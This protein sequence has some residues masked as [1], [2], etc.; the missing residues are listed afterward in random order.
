ME[1]YRLLLIL[2]V[3][4]AAVWVGGHLVLSSTVLPRALRAQDPALLRDFE[5]RYERIGI[6]ALLVQVVTGVWLAHRWLPQPALWFTLNAPLSALVFAKFLLL[7]LT[8]VL[9]AH[10]R[11]RVIPRLAAGNLRFLAF[12]ILL[13]TALGVGF[14]VLGVGIRTGG[15]W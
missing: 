4:A 14:V 10:A 5:G 7:G 3:L 8:V 13:V 15:L 2:H 11:L 9:A 6:P 1:L 12:H